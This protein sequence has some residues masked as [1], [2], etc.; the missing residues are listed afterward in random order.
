MQLLSCVFRGNDWKVIPNS[1]FCLEF[2]NQNQE[3]SMTFDEIVKYCT[4]KPHAEETYP[5]DEV[6]LVMKIG[7]KMFA[8]LDTEGMETINLKHDTEL[9]PELLVNNSC[10]KPGYH[11]SKKHWITLHYTH[12]DMHD[13]DILKLID[14]SY[15]MVKS[16][17]PK[18]MKAILDISF[19]L[20]DIQSPAYK[21]ALQLRQDILRTPLNMTMTDK[22]ITG[23]D[24]DIHIGGF[25]EG[26]LIAYCIISRIDNQ[27]AKIRQVAVSSKLQGA[28]IGT[29]L[30]GFAEDVAMG[31]GYRT[32]ILHARK[33]VIQWYESIGYEIIGDEFQEV[34]IPHH[35]MFKNL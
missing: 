23:E 21:Q 27:V 16:S 19:S 32:I 10:I 25:Y 17:L 8:L 15:E 22:D 2:T 6:T 3:K 13:S 20:F 31:R 14:R 18:K 4:L 34:G 28:G 35:K 1:L 7:G 30:M 12:A 33:T 24:L 9:I 5:F 29:K 26:D 11:M